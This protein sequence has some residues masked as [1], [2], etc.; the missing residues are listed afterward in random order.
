MR[1]VY[2]FFGILCL[3]CPYAFRQKNAFDSSAPVV[4]HHERSYIMT[5]H[6]VQCSH[7]HNYISHVVMCMFEVDEGTIVS[8]ELSQNAIKATNS[9][10][11]F[12]LSYLEISE[13]QL[14]KIGVC[15]IILTSFQYKAFYLIFLFQ[16]ID[17]HIQQE[18]MIFQNWK[19][20]ING[21]VILWQHH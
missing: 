14:L 8:L 18:S 15:H 21:V 4:A 10:F 5:I 20:G 6:G 13:F 19:N 2:F 17:A 7:I 1:L 12:A 16:L 11:D 9:T 3:L